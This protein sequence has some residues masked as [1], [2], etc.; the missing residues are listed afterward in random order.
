M[1]LLSKLLG[2]DKKAEKAAKD[3]LTGLLGNAQ[4][5]T[6][7]QNNQNSSVNVPPAARPVSYASASGFSWGEDM[8]NEENQFNFNGT[9]TQYF[10]SIFNSD[11]SSYRYEKEMLRGGSRIVYTFYGAVGKVLVVELMPE[12]SSAYKLRND[13]K[14]SNIAYLRF[15]YNHHGWW[16][17]RS[18]VV[19]RMRS[20]LKG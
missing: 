7:N 13:C 12:S 9:F 17:T 15:Y 19:S 5:N 10:E 3:F 8:P 1:S 11:F 6:V 2:G 14:N 4:Q 16:N 20:V 18:Y